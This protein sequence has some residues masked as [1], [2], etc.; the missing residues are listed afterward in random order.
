MKIQVNA[1]N[2]IQ[3]HVRVWDAGPLF[4]FHLLD[5]DQPVEM[6]SYSGV[7]THI[8]TPRYPGRFR[9]KALVKSGPGPRLESISEEVYVAFDEFSPQGSST[10]PSFVLTG[11]SQTTLAA[12][13]IMA[14]ITPVLAIISPIHAGKNV[15]GVPVVDRAPEGVVKLVDLG[16]D[17]FARSVTPLGPMEQDLRTVIADGLA[18]KDILS[19]HRMSSSLLS[20]GFKNASQ[21]LDEYIFRRFNSRVPASVKIGEG[22]VL[23]YGGIGTVI[24]KNAIIGRNCVIGQNVTIGARSSDA[25]P[26]IG[27]NVYVGPHAVCIGGSIGANVVVGAGAVVTKPVESNC[28]VAGVP[29]RV[30]STDMWKYRGYTRAYR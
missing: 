22:T 1:V 29:A 6:T 8:F 23:G 5:G 9:V 21:E 19:V 7:S 15:F 10:P 12:V 3:I 13:L 4:A 27:D 16:R 26:V 25:T 11:L 30:V 20:S 17:R 14:E 28:V 18:D 2:G 24:N